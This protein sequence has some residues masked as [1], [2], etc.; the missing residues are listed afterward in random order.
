M[1]LEP[2]PSQAEGE[3][4]SAQCSSKR[5]YKRTNK[6]PVKNSFDFK[7]QTLGVFENSDIVKNACILLNNQFIELIKN[8]ATDKIHELIQPQSNSTISNS[9]DL[10]LE[11]IGYT[12]GKVIEY[13]LHDKYYSGAMILSY[14]GFRK[15]HPHDTHSTIRVAFKDD[16]SAGLQQ[17]SEIFTDVCQIAI[18][19]YKSI[20]SGF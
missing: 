20:E 11:G 13:L 1:L 12:V 3:A 14:V 15:D 17:L 8:L 4:C 9:Y 7:I 18:K 5:L 10:K 2:S 19:I 16:E 6:G